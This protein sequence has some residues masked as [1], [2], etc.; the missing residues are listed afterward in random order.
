M[1]ASC[2]FYVYIRIKTNEEIVFKCLNMTR[3]S[4]FSCHFVLNPQR[5]KL[6]T[7]KTTETTKTTTKI[8][9]VTII[10]GL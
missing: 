8:A 5:I 3:S 1:I 4:T 10:V 7:V 2:N 6:A 9:A